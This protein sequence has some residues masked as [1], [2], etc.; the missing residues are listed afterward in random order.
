MKGSKRGRRVVAQQQVQSTEKLAKTRAEREKKEAEDAAASAAEAQ[1]EISSASAPPPAAPPQASAAAAPL[2]SAVALRTFSQIEIDGMR[3]VDLKEE[4]VNRSLSTKGLKAVLKA[5]LVVSCAAQ[6]VI[7]EYVLRQVPTEQW[8]EMSP[9]QR[10][11]WQNRHD[12]ESA[13]GVII[14]EGSKKTTLLP[15][16][17]LAKVEARRCDECNVEKLRDC[18]SKTQWERIKYEKKHGKC[19]CCIIKAQQTKNKEEGEAHKKKAKKFNIPF[20]DWAAMTKSQRKRYTQKQNR[21]DAAAVAAP[22]AK[23]EEEKAKQQVKKGKNEKHEEMMMELAKGA[24]ENASAGVLASSGAKSAITAPA[25]VEEEHAEEEEIGVS[26]DD[27]MDVD[28]PSKT[29]SARRRKKLQNLLLGRE[30]SRAEAEAAAEVAAEVAADLAAKAD[31]EAGEVVPGG[32]EAPDLTSTSAPD[33]S[34]ATTKKKKKNI[35]AAD[36]AAMTRGQ[37]WNYLYRAKNQNRRDAAAVAAPPAVE[38]DDAEGGE[39]KPKVGGGYGGYGNGGGGG[40][41]YGGGYGNGGGYGGYGNGGGGGHYQGGGYPAYG[42]GGG[43]DARRG[44]GGRGYDR[45]GDRGGRREE[46]RGDR[47]YDRRDERRDDHDDRSRARR[48]RDDRRRVER[49]VERRSRSRS[50]PRERDRD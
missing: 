17:E 42:G 27:D 45:R 20:A 16:L 7:S 46:R 5:R 50:P 8:A 4:L 40:G 2:H 39:E 1:E 35:S 26:E 30:A 41:G 43:Y 6:E 11:A 32:G 15:E 12:S 33:S 24:C 47:G 9:Q 21:R 28:V 44:G 34:E 14:M 22:P 18:F 23:I 19:A 29:G 36:W 13:S 38:D 48:R 10:K 37:R 25:M 49:R 3:V 31:T